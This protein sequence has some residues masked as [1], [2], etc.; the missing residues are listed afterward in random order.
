MGSVVAHSD[1]SDGS[2]GSA[3]EQRPTQGSTRGSA[4]SGGARES[5][6]ETLAREAVG[7]GFSKT[8]QGSIE[9]LRVPFENFAGYVSQSGG[10]SVVAPLQ[11][12]VDAAVLTKD[13]TVFGSRPVE[14]LLEFKWNA[15]VKVRWVRQ[16][17]L[18]MVHVFLA[19]AYNLHVAETVPLSVR[20]VFGLNGGSPY[21]GLLSGWLWTTTYSL[22]KGIEE[23]QEIR[24]G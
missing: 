14:I 12:I 11:L 6:L 22:S 7:E 20:D 8:S 3:G 18:F 9:A 23:M 24:A 21:W 16:S 15:F 19:S 2:S 1:R 5:A 4:L 13:F 10:S 17:A